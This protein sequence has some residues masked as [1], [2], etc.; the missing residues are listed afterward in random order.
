MGRERLPKAMLAQGP[1]PGASLRRKLADVERRLIAEALER[2]G[3]VM[4]RAAA[5]LEVD[6]VTLARRARKLGLAKPSPL[7]ATAGRGSG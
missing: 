3:G 1:A 5:A 2:S 4:R 7:P 6:A